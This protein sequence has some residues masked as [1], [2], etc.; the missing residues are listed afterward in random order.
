MILNSASVLIIFSCQITNV[1]INKI[2]TT[3]KMGN[4]YVIKILNIFEIIYCVNYL[5]T[6]QQFLWC[7]CVY[8]CI[9][10]L[11]K[12]NTKVDGDPSLCFWDME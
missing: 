1:I 11:D 8:E 2:F 5:W 3:Y 6:L 10:G 9:I 7:V 4:R 12:I